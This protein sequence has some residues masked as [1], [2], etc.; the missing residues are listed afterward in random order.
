LTTTLVPASIAGMRDRSLSRRGE[1]GRLRALGREA[2]ASFGVGQA[3]L[4][5]LR[6]ETNTTFRVDAAG[7][8][9]VLRISRA[10]TA[11]AETIASEM[12]WLAALRTRTGLSVPEPVAAA[13]GTFVTIASHPDVPGPRACVLLRWMNGRFVDAGLAPRHLSRVGELMAGLQNHAEGWARPAGFVRHRVDTLTSIA[14]SASV[15]D[16]PTPA[17]TLVPSRDDADR[18]LGLAS[19]LLSVAAARTV[20]EALDRVWDTTRRL[21]TGQA[22]AGLIHGDLHQENYFFHA[23]A[24][25]AIDFDDC[26]WGFHLYDLAVTISEIEGRPGYERLRDAFLGAYA[27]RRALPPDA[28]VHLRALIILRRVQLLMWILESREHAAFRDDWHPWAS[29]ELRGLQ[30]ALTQ[31]SAVG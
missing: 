29:K 19:D 11:T 30:A 15:G 20:A 22:S 7:D 2:L 28:D 23:G 12:M 25:R 21:T 16:S 24:A 3:R 31:A 10:G 17:T 13:D 4:T 26:G 6:H 9:Y 14:N 27:R 18:A 1:I 8:R 5:L